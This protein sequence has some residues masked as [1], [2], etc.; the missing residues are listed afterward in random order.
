VIIIDIIWG[1]SSASIVT[2]LN[3]I[4]FMYVSAKSGLNDFKDDYTFGQ[5]IVGN[6][7]LLLF[8]IGR[9]LGR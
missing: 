8:C 5:K 6:I 9:Q 4:H 1:V 7:F 3:I 2:I